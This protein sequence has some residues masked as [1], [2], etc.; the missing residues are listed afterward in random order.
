MH[1]NSS[2]EYQPDIDGIRAI[3]VIA[4]I[5]FHLGVFKYGYLGVDVFFVLSGYLIT[6]ILLNDTNDGRLDIKRFYLR[7][8]R[9]ILPLVGVVCFVA[10]ILGVCFMLPHDLDGL[11]QS[12]IATLLFSNNILEYIVVE[13]YWS[14]SN[15]Y[16]PLMHTWSLGIEE[17]FYVVYPF[18]LWAMS[19]IKLLSKYLV[20]VLAICT[21]F[22]LV[23]YLFESNAHRSFYWLPFRFYEISIGGLIA[24]LSLSSKEWGN[25]LK[26]F[27]LGAA[28]TFLIFVFIQQLE[29]WYPVSIVLLIS[30]YLF[31]DRS[32]VSFV[33][34]LLSIPILVNI[35]ILSFSLYMWHHLVFAFT[36]YVFVD[37]FNIL[38]VLIMLFITLIL[39][40]LSYKF[41]EKK[42]RSQR[43][44]LKSV[45]SFLFIMM[46]LLLSI[47]LFIYFKG[48]VV[49][50][51]S[52]LELKAGESFRNMHLHYN[53]RHIKSEKRFSD[54]NKI[55]VSVIGNSFAR[56][57]INV[58][59]ES[60]YKEE[61][62]I[63]YEP[64]LKKTPSVQESIKAANIVFT[65]DYTK[66]QLRQYL[67]NE[68]FDTDKYWSIGFKNYGKNNGIFFNKLKDENYCDQHVKPNQGILRRHKSMKEE[69]GTTYIDLIN[70]AMNDVGEV[71]VFT[72]DCKFISQDCKHFT[73]AGARHFARL[74]ENDSLGYGLDVVFSSR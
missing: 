10:L 59:L 20:I 35:G 32:D 22:S 6:L 25:A 67:P 41:V 48:G 40:M 33:Y 5:L 1:H 29:V 7:R 74:L 24:A 56:D 12:I 27:M 46:S 61:I 2:I 71:P 16:K 53:T 62:Q 18:V 69:W 14:I 30:T 60:K 57:W 68:N 23:I 15:E 36:R 73:P 31:L 13:D 47:S 28:V 55:K 50:D 66:S 72:N 42:Y 9:R 19:R 52:T 11:V 58:L 49:R 63:W 17:Q 38:T 21:L 43:T 65:F 26:Y 64:L 3:S 37:E 70:L 54:P 39:S 44:S 51:I 8:I 34:K 45:F 4:V